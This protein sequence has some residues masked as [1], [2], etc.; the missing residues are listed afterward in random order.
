MKEFLSCNVPAIPAE[1]VPVRSKIT[2][3]S[4]SDL[5]KKI[6]RG[7]ELLAGKIKYGFAMSPWNDDS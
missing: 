5:R 2:V 7:Y 6:E 4:L 3:Y 1:I